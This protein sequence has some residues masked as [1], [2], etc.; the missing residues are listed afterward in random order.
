M[1]RGKNPPAHTL[2]GTRAVSS[3]WNCFPAGG[4]CIRAKAPDGVVLEAAN[5]IGAAEII[6][7]TDQQLALKA[8]SDAQR[9]LEEYLE[10][11]PH[12][13]ER[14]LEML[15]D[16]LERPDVLVAVRR[17]QRGGF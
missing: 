1:I 16:V 11:R 3:G 14:I 6:I 13:D 17:L 5:S 4:F 15:V 7:M 2:H 9:I 12:N 10:P 8:M